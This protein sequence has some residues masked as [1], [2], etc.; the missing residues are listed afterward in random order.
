MEIGTLALTK[1]S[2]GMVRTKMK[3]ERARRVVRWPKRSREA[4]MTRGKM[5]PARPVPAHMTPNAR[6]LRLMN[7]PSRKT[8]HSSVTVHLIVM[9]DTYTAGAYINAPPIAY[10]TPCVAI[11]PPTVVAKEL[12]AK[13]R[14]S[15]SNPTTQQARC[16][17]GH[18]RI[19]A[20]TTG[21]ETCGSFVSVVMMIARD[22]WPLTVHDALRDVV[23]SGSCQTDWRRI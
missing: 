10:I 23:S 16:I 11:S 12:Q 17:C 4:P 20:K 7:Q 5:T 3:T 8:L 13:L 18:R 1:C 14:H 19:M 22:G 21:A 6:P 9:R 15:S 2:R